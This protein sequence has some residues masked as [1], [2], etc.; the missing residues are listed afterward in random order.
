MP[1]RDA[2]LRRIGWH[3][4]LLAT[5]SCLLVPAGLAVLGSFKP[6]ATLYGDDPLPTRPTLANYRVALTDFPVGRLLGNTLITAA[7]VMILQLA[8]AML[9]AY[10]L[11][12]LHTR[13]ARVLLAAGTVAVL[14]PAQA[15]LVPQFLMISKLG[16]LNSFT[17][18]IV[19]QLSGCAVA[20]L[21]LH[22]QVRA[23][24]PS[25]CEAAMLD[26]ASS[27]QTL[28]RVV[29]PLMRSALASVG[30]LV[31]INTWNEYLWPLIA[32]PGGSPGTIQTGL[33]LFLN[34]EGA[35]P[36]PLL[37]AATLSTVPVLAV[38]LFTAQRVT[39]AFMQSGLE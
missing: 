28:W 2:P 21:L 14:V 17:G 9:A 37:A 1:G 36:G 38:Y 39:G 4:G 22:Q 32:T 13:A 33:A 31:F 16:W 8:V 7:G 35:N 29:L 11:A 6:P 30:T 3:L 10:A 19:P 5:A 15:L 25:L 12:R 23:I 26:G 34:T 20:L 18:L 24:P 27:W